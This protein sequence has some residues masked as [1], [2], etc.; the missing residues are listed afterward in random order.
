M[1]AENGGLANLSL[2]A[3]LAMLSSC[4]IAARPYAVKE[5]E[6]PG[7]KPEP[8]EP[9]RVEPFEPDIASVKLTDMMCANHPSYFK[10]AIQ[11]ESH[12][13]PR[14]VAKEW[15]Q[16]RGEPSR[17]ELETPAHLYSFDVTGEP[18][19]VA[20]MAWTL[21]PEDG[22]RLYFGL[23]N[24]AGRNS[25]HFSMNHGPFTRMSHYPTVVVLDCESEDMEEALERLHIFVQGTR[26]TSILSGV[27]SSSHGPPRYM[28][29]AA[30]QVG[31]RF[32]GVV[33]VK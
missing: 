8:A 2:L 10:F 19:S 6:P 28:L 25:S 21:E 24:F 7:V 20:V 14:S 27:V 29:H 32:D 12:H 13:F 1:R 30:E 23:S 5:E 18:R 3:A 11:Y 4:A 33:K 31:T 15:E 17:V 9:K 16:A 22:V 26:V